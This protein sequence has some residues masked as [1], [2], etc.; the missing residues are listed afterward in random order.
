MTLDVTEIQ[1]GTGSGFVWDQNGHIVTNFHVVQM[2]DRASVTLNDDTTYPAKIVGVAPDK[3]LA[4]LQIEAPPQKLLPL[5]IGQSANLKVG[6][7]VARDRQ[8]VR[9][10]P[11]A[12][13]RRD[14][15]PR[16]RDQERCRARR[17]T[18]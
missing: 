14:L 6:Q 2:G 4:V 18:T 12:D 17:S 3:D 5:P 13:H 9:P 1:Q 15:R 11:D 7:K 8:P 16:P 10:R